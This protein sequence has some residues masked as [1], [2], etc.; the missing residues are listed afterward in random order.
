MSWFGAQ[1]VDVLAYLGTQTLYSFVVACVVLI[2]LR[3]FRITSP[4]IHLYAWALVILR[5]LIP[6]ELASPYSL[7]SLLEFVFPDV[8]IGTSHVAVLPPPSSEHLVA[9]VE[10]GSS[11]GLWQSIVVMSWLLVAAAL[12]IVVSSRL[13]RYRQIARKADEIRTKSL[14]YITEQWRH[15]LQ[16]R[17]KVRLV[18]SEMCLSPFTTGFIA[19]KIFLPT[20]VM[21]WSR[22]ELESIIAHEMVH[23]QRWDE[24][25]IVISNLA[26][27]MHF[28]NPVAT[29]ALI[30]MNQAREQL[31]DSDVMAQSSIPPREYTRALLNIIKLN[32]FGPAAI[33]AIVGMVDRKE[34]IKMRV[35]HLQTEKQ[36]RRI[37]TIWL[38][39][40]FLLCAL[41][42]LPMAELESR[43]AAHSAAGFES[44]SAEKDEL[45]MPRRI[46]GS[47]PGLTEA[48][49]KN[50]TTGVVVL[51]VTVAE[52]GSVKDVTVLRPQS[53]GLTESAVAAVR[54][55]KYKPAER[56]GKKIELAVSE[57]LVFRPDDLPESE[58]IK[59]VRARI[60]RG[61][62]IEEL[63]QE[64]AFVHIKAVTPDEYLAATTI[65]SLDNWKGSKEVVLKN[66]IRTDDGFLF[67]ITV[68]PE[69]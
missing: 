15:K 53:D 14:L 21:T 16:I 8:S 34:G 68:T 44:A 25:W 28:F 29:L 4:I 50:G 54:Q 10:A 38:L 49:K 52:D 31:C 47:R 58:I 48:A 19:P 33:D 45:I 57:V 30:E 12:C 51:Q 20:A 6:A 9:T 67:H 32:Q 1:S 2:A 55:W 7:R 17:R 13:F 39:P 59:Q 23:I 62:V 22:P 5:L 41:F 66:M 61:I 3:V 37:K 18:S 40:A 11:S 69:Q 24:L 63:Y 60:P 64:G 42:I 65:S 56:N 27:C 43:A 36:T 35:I 46:S 26:R